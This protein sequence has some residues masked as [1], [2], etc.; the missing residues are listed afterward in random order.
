MSL[1]NGQCSHK[2]CI[3]YLSYHYLFSLGKKIGY[4][5]ARSS[6]CQIWGSIG[7]QLSPLY[8]PIL[9]WVTKEAC[10]CVRCKCSGKCV[11]RLL[12]NNIKSHACQCWGI[13]M[14]VR[15]L[16]HSVR[17][18]ARPCD[19]P[20]SGSQYAGEIFASVHR[21]KITC[22]GEQGQLFHNNSVSPLHR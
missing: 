22:T 6:L 7:W 21:Y 17:V 5:L 19:R 9:F 16:L 10:E 8:P 14:N 13:S 15:T 11:S 1:H 12:F 20:T 4:L 18:Y 3:E 2:E